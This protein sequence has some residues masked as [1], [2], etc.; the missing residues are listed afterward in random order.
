M[1][2]SYRSL[3]NAIGFANG[4]GLSID[5]PTTSY[6][7]DDTGLFMASDRPGSLEK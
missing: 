4:I 2:F 7:M 5:I 3:K 6:E 1:V